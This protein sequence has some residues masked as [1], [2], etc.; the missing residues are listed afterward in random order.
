MC[1]QKVM[2]KLNLPQD[3]RRYQKKYVCFSLLVQVVKRPSV[4]LCTMLF[5]LLSLKWNFF[6][7][8]KLN[9]RLYT[10]CFI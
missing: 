2:F 10:T 1:E 7:N 5:S 6:L 8:Y 4:C 9:F 3:I